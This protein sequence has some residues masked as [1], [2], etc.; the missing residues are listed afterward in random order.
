MPVPRLLFRGELGPD[1]PLWSES[2][3]GLD[4]SHFD[5]TA[6]LKLRLTEWCIRGWARYDLSDQGRYSASDG[7]WAAWVADGRPLFEETRAALVGVG[8]PFLPLAGFQASI[9]RRSGRVFWCRGTD[10]VL[11]ATIDGQSYLPGRPCPGGHERIGGSEDA[12]VSTS[13]GD[14]FGDGRN[15]V[16]ELGPRWFC[17]G[18]CD[19]LDCRARWV[20][21]G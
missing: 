14:F 11:E 20:G 13:C 16:G 7:D 21:L 17:C 4:L 8:S 2:G 6:D 5:L 9:R 19:D 15:A 12:E 10:R 1:S 18:R 3:I